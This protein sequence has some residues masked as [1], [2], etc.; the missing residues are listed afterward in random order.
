MRQNV[1]RGGAVSLMAAA[2]L[3][4]PGSSFAG[5]PTPG[6]DCGAGASVVG[7]QW[8]GKVTMGASVATCTLTFTVPFLNS[9]A[10]VATN[11]T[12]GGPIATQSTASWVVF[13][14][15]PLTGAILS[16]GDVVS[17]ICMSY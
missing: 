6:P 3:L 2:L 9:P 7:S 16:S 17:Y 15:G 5:T 1:L 13:A 4:W 11:E 12:N 14:V 8:G 10:C